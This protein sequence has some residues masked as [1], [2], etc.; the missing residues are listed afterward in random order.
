MVCVDTNFLIELLRKKQGA[1]NKL[2]EIVK[3][4]EELKTTTINASELYKGAYR[5][6]KQKEVIRVDQIL[7]SLEVLP[8]NQ[9]SAKLFG[10]LYYDPMIKPKNP[11]DMD[12]LIAS[13][14]L[15]SGEKFL[16]KNLRH[17]DF[18]PNLEVE[19]W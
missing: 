9:E 2:K 10:K 5:G 19:T 11:G 18:I 12:L 17:F 15:I 16:T 13:I 14:T 6:Q 3:S 7:N 4:G 1:I 8:H